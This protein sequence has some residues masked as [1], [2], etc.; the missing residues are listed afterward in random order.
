MF[1]KQETRDAF[2][3]RGFFIPYMENLPFAL[4]LAFVVMYMACHSQLAA[5][6]QPKGRET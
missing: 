4:T 6:Q 5:G 3:R 1:P 2:M